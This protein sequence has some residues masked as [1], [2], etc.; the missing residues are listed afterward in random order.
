MTNTH[1]ITK[2]R[3]KKRVGRGGARGT[4]A[5]HGHKGQKSRAGHR[6]RPA[7]RDELQRIPKRRGHNKNRARGVRYQRPTRS[8]TLRMLNS[9]FEA[10]SMVSPSILVQK[11]LIAPVWGQIPTVKIVSTGEV[12][13]A[14][15]VTK[16]LASE[17]A[18]QKIEAAG[19]TL[20]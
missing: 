14:L 10:G 6:I 19:G 16:C 4:N 13:V 11:R 1:F 3:K 8:V 5:G 20:R 17:S 15:N 2:T 9:N 12:S 18:R 7:L